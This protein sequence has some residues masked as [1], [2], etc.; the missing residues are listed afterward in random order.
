MTRRPD[1][2]FI[3][4]PDGRP[5]YAVLAYDDY[6]ALLDGAGPSSARR[7]VG[8]WERD[9]DGPALRLPE[10]RPVP[11]EVAARIAAGENPILVWRE[12]RGLDREILAGWIGFDEADVAAFEDGSLMPTV[13]ICQL[14]ANAL[15]VPIEAVIPE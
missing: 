4:G 11:P 6:L 8:A 10:P 12:H 5:A 14:I 3:A 13:E 9:E 1:V 7:D 2:Q 15:D